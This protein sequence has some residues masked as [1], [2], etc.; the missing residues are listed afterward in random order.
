MAVTVGLCWQRCQKLCL[1]KSVL[2]GSVGP[3]AARAAATELGGSINR[4]SRH[5]GPVGAAQSNRLT[6]AALKAEHL[7]SHACTH[8]SSC[9]GG[10][11]SSSYGTS[12]YLSSLPSSLRGALMA[13]ICPRSVTGRL[14]K[15]LSLPKSSQ[16][17]GN[18]TLT[19]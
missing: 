12:L 17:G 3:A 5:Q 8:D 2:D 19:A 6:S 10:T 14:G 18:Q 4:W 16:S 15:P 1:H 7:Q 9:S 11:N 13:A